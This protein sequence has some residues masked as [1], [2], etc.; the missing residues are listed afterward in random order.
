MTRP[1]YVAWMIICSEAD[2]NDE[3][4]EGGTNERAKV[5]QS[6]RHAGAEFRFNN[7]NNNFPRDKR[8]TG[9]FIG[10]GTLAVLWPSKVLS[11]FFFSV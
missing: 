8:R 10:N 9:N 5:P 6:A 1:L 7:N 3:R 11:W 4:R 2:D